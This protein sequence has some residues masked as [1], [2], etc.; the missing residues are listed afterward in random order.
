M[1]IE[2]H[3]AFALLADNQVEEAIA[4]AAAKRS[5]PT[6]MNTSHAQLK[7]QSEDQSPTTEKTAHEQED[8]MVT[9]RSQGDR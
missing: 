8:V 6:S 4:A 7:L 1:K 5:K 9:M 2:Y 3:N